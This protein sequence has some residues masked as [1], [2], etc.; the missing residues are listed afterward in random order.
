MG[1]VT[2]GGRRGMVSQELLFVMNVN[3]DSKGA[4]GA[5]QVQLLRHSSSHIRP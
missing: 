2:G 5:G 4:C 1:L 3:L